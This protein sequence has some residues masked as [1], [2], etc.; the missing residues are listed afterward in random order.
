MVNK[1]KFMTRKGLNLDLV[2]I[3]DFV[4]VKKYFNGNKLNG[5]LASTFPESLKIKKCSFLANS[6][7]GIRIENDIGKENHDKTTPFLFEKCVISDNNNN[8][9]QINFHRSL[10]RFH[11]F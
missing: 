9:G 2:A 7:S 6:E 1:H 4:G 5:I 3:N 8:S 11:Y 10:Y